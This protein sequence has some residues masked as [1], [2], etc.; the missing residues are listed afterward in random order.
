MQS[1]ERQHF[2][3]RLSR[4]SDQF[5]G[6]RISLFRKKTL[7]ESFELLRMHAIVAL[8][9]TAGAKGIG[10]NMKPMKMQMSCIAF[11]LVFVKAEIN[12]EWL[13]QMM[14]S[15]QFGWVFIETGCGEA[16]VGSAAV[17]KMGIH[18]CGRLDDVR[19]TDWDIA[20][21]ASRMWRVIARRY[22]LPHLH[23]SLPSSGHSWFCHNFSPFI[24][25]PFLQLP[26]PPL[27]CSSRSILCYWYAGFPGPPFLPLTFPQLPG[28]CI[29]QI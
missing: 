24:T 28:G 7:S 15:D 13:R 27:P 18:W 11:A 3:S 6:S 23:N 20:V 10:A 19:K 5:A 16:D 17:W 14:N 8:T 12:R 1:R 29:C 21:I 22:F 25:F 4:F 26:A 9:A 2:V